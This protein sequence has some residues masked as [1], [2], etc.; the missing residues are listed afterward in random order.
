MKR[1]TALLLFTVLLTCTVFLSSCKRNEAEDYAAALLDRCIACEA[2]AVA[3]VMGYDVQSLTEI[4]CYTL[5]RMQYK[6]VESKQLDGHRWDVT[7]DTKLFDIMN[8]LNEALIYSYLST[9]QEGTIDVNVW[10][11][12]QLNTEQAARGYFRAVLPLIRSDDGTW[13]TD[14]DRIG[15]D[16]RDA[17]SGG[18]FSWYKAYS[19]TFGEQSGTETT[20]PLT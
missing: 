19:E 14:P 15:D 16:V 18:A 10:V 4:E 12:E 6:I 9:E 5:S 3:A 7:F 8:L 20:D 1:L 17:I 2:D 11:L 13:S